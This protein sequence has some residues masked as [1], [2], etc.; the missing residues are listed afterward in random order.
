MLNE[1]IKSF[2]LGIWAGDFAEAYSFLRV[3]G[4]FQTMAHED[5]RLELIRPPLK[6][7]QPS[8]T[9]DWIQQCDAI[10]IHHPLSDEHLHV[11]ATA[12]RLGRPVWSELVDDIFNISRH[13]PMAKTY[14]NK[15]A[16]RDNI[17]G[18]LDLSNV[19]TT[20]SQLCKEALV[21]GCD[22]DSTVR[23]SL[24]AQ[25]TPPSAKIVVLPEAAFFEPSLL[26]RKKCISWRG[27]NTHDD[28]TAG[29]LDQVCRVARDFPDWEWA[30]FGAPSAEFVERL[31]EA[32]GEERVKVSPLWPTPWDMFEAWKGCAPYLHLVPLEDNLFNQSKSH[33]AYLEATACGAA[34]IVPDYLPEWQQPGVIPYSGGAVQFEGKLNLEA[35]LRREM[36]NYP[37]NGK[38]H[39]N[40]AAARE[41]VYPGRTLEAMNALRWL[42]I[43]KLAQKGGQLK[44][45][46]AIGV[47]HADDPNNAPEPHLEVVR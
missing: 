44:P 29:V 3:A 31:Q 35:V 27:L 4:P 18:A 39:P 24:I 15:K 7:G 46:G 41:F 12:R 14:A 9:W 16:V 32:A 28:D 40:V 26:P 20:T 30:L 38:L 10:F 1:N 21:K 42:V 22:L 47:S 43:N 34:V 5:R 19:V 37:H 11:M 33:L 8:L 45:K 25:P 17:T 23:K 36:V 13:S 2:R 6:D